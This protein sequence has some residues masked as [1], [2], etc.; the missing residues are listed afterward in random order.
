MQMKT[1][2]ATTKLPTTVEIHIYSRRKSKKES[3]I[4]ELWLLLAVSLSVC[5]SV[6]AWHCFASAERKKE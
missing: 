1:N 6:S 2:Q 5:V 3:F 4:A